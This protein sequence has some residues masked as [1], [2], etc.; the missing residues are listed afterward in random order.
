MQ[1][2]DTEIILIYWGC[3]QAW[4]NTHFL[5]M[6]LEWTFIYFYI[7]SKSNL[8]AVFGSLILKWLMNEWHAQ[9][10]LLLSVL[11]I[12]NQFYFIPVKVGHCWVS[13]TFSEENECTWREVF[14]QMPF[15]IPFVLGAECWFIVTPEDHRNHYNICIINEPP[16]SV[17]NE[18][19]FQH[20]HT[21]GSPHEWEPSEHYEN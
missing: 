9:L 21:S 10:I 1:T 13:G 4:F 5:L 6:L 15:I 12:N 7:L 11:K 17:P 16:I 14:G 19:H 2:W 20:F 3:H 18:L 8:R